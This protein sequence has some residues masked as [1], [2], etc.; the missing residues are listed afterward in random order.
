M[1][2]KNRARGFTLLELL[3]VIGIIAIVI[4]ILMPSLSA[5]RSRGKQTACANN[6]RQLGLA[7]RSYL[8]D[9]SDVFPYASF[10]P[11]V[12]PTPVDGDAI[13]LA[14]VLVTHTAGMDKVFACP[15][16]TGGI[17]RLA[18]NEGKSYYETEKSSYDYRFHLGGE[19]MAD[20]LKKYAEFT[21]QH[22]NEN[23]LWILR[24]YDNFHGDG[25]KPGARRY[26]YYDGHVTDFEN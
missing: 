9:N 14:D 6:L 15:N 16:D 2:I 17:P 13:Y 1:N 26:V 8:D 7:M 20:F 11:S 22:V 12:D 5:A 19:T 24:D 3:V 21:G 4:S 25:G 18:P 23:T 10:M